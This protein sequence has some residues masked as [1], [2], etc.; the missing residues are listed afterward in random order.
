MRKILL[1]RSS[2]SAGDDVYNNSKEIEVDEQ[3]KLTQILDKIIDMG[4]LPKIAGG[5]A[6]WSV[7]YKNPLAVIAQQWSKPRYIGGIMSEFPFSNDYKDFD[8]LHFNYH[9]QE[10]PELVYTIIGQFRSAFPR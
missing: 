6:T 7:A 1:T 10:N 4:Y 3:W 8:R 5:K 9:V 2:V